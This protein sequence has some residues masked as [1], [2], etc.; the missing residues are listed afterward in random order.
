MKKI[1]LISVFLAAAFSVFAQ[2]ISSVGLFPFEIFV[3]REHSEVSASEAADATSQV[4]NILNTSGT[5]TLLTGDRAGS[6]EYHIRGRISRL[7]AQ[8]NQ[9]VLA[10][11]TSE[12]SSGRTLNSSR[13][14]VSALDAASIFSFCTQV[15][16]NIPYPVHHVGRWQSVIDT[17]DGPIMC[18]MEFMPDR[19]ILVERFDTWEHKGTNSMRYQAIG[20]GTYSFAGH[21]LY[22]TFNA[23]G[24][25]IQGNATFGIDLA[26]EDSLPKYKI[27]HVTTMAFLYNEAKTG[28]EL[29]NAGIPCGDNFSGPSVYPGS[30][31]FYT[32][33]TRIR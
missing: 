30:E 31:V 11:T 29:V 28:F 7:S 27:I 12:A 17:V 21:H 3:D 20:T 13:A 16:S 6:A 15:V 5:L 33:F 24:K 19:T 9:F 1:L 22:R 23:G 14:Q 4:I 18:I 10:A 8:N 25:Q 26:L 2:R 32:V